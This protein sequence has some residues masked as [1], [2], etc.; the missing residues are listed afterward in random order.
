MMKK[1]ILLGILALLIVGMVCAMPVPKPMMFAF[2]YSGTP[3]VN[4]AVDFTC[5]PQSVTKM[6]NSLGKIQIDVG[7]A[8]G[9]FT[10]NCETLV[11]NDG[12]NSNT[13]TG[14]L[15]ANFPQERII[16]L[17]SAPA[18]SCTPTVCPSTSCSSGGSGSYAIPVTQEACDEKFT[19]VPVVCPVK[20]CTA[21]EC[22]EVTCPA[23][24]VCVETVCQNEDCDDSTGIA[25]LTLILGAAGGAGI[26]FGLFNKKVIT[27]M[28]T[29][30]KI[31]RGNDG[32]LKFHHKHPGTS[33]YHDTNVKHR[34]PETHPPGE[35]DVAE[36]YKKN[37]SGD[38]EYTG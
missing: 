29:G 32:T 25:W 8:G 3:V 2:E 24:K 31:Y 37:A 36:G 9:D 26:L 34:S 22:E 35:M 27:G 19:V 28:R 5:G 7:D 23:E 14:L 17:A 18:P 20:T 6:T 12:T 30:I 13:Y 21:E 33:G 38:W 4:L 15:A 10:I 1:I 11:V 16:S